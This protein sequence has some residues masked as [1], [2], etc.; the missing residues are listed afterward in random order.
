MARKVSLVTYDENTGYTMDL[1]CLNAEQMITCANCNV[2]GNLTVAGKSVPNED[3]VNELLD[4]L[5]N[6]DVFAKRI[7]DILV[8]NV[9]SSSLSSANFSIGTTCFIAIESQSMIFAQGQTVTSSQECKLFPM[10]I[11]TE[12]N[13]SGEHVVKVV[14]NATMTLEGQWRLLTSS[15]VTFSSE[16]KI[17][18]ALAIR[19]E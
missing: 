1:G 4:A 12:T 14:S 15:A 10:H 19:V 13:S 17:A 8:G 2:S 9:I 16:K 5:I 3:R 11:S 6:S 18:I 7:A